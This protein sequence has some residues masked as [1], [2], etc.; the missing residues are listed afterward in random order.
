MSSVYLEQ[1]PAGSVAMAVA[2][3]PDPACQEKP[4]QCGSSHEMELR[5]MEFSTPCRK[6]NLQE[7]PC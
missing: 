1:R 6:L 4:R 7:C 5:E 2:S 3:G